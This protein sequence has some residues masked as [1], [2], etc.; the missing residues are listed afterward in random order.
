MKQ[1][2]LLLSGFALLTLLPG[3][4]LSASSLSTSAIKK[5]TAPAPIQEVSFTQVHLN[6]GFWS[7]RIEINRTV[8]IPS[9]FHECEV[10]GRFDN[11]ALAAGLIKGEHKGDFSFD[12]ALFR[13]DSRI[14]FHRRAISLDFS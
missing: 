3:P 10:N 13:P 12:L 4:W 11:F 1:R 5:T 7:P 8:S 6:D 14:R 9:A 2:A